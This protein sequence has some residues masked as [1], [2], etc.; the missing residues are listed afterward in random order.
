MYLD[1]TDCILTV[2]PQNS[3]INFILLKGIFPQVTSTIQFTVQLTIWKQQ[4]LN[5]IY[6][7]GDR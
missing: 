7:N 5:V 2:F 3:H 1:G 4:D 6:M